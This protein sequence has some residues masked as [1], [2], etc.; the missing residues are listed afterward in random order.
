MSNPT[1]VQMP[2]AQPPVDFPYAHPVYIVDQNGNLLT[3][4]GSLVAAVGTIGSA[5]PASGDF[6]AGSDGTNL[7]GLLVESA[8]HPNLRIGL[9][10]GANEIT[11]N[12][13]TYTAKFGLDGNLLGTLGTAF[14]TAG[15]VD[16]KGADGDVFVR[17][18]TGTNLH[19]V[20]DTTSTTAVTQTTAANLNGTFI[21]PGFSYA[22]ITTK[23]TTTP[24]SGA[25]VLHAIMI[26]KPGSTDTLT[27]YDNTTNSAPIIASITV[28][29]SVGFMYVFNAA[30]TTGLTIVSGGGTAGDYTVLYR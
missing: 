14:S 22:N 20:L 7:Q 30:F 27:V 11:A 6:L 13:T 15:K 24:K 12:S 16:V 29:A 8:S 26:N 23:T 5:V 17:Q 19:V 1:T 4:I 9:Y 18:T 10:N 25:G 3:S 28:T 21:W 2:V